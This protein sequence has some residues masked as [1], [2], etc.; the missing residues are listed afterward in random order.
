M[1]DHYAY[2]G[3]R[4]PRSE[5]KHSTT[6]TDFGVIF[7]DWG[8]HSGTGQVLYSRSYH[9]TSSKAREFLVKIATRTSVLL[10]ASTLETSLGG[11]CRLTLL[12]IVSDPGAWHPW[13]MLNICRTKL[14]AHTALDLH[15]TALLIFFRRPRTGIPPAELTCHAVAC[16]RG[17]GRHLLLFPQSGSRGPGI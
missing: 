5:E 15:S 1:K 7:R 12:W 4:R 11:V 13:D 9:K 2:P 10:R 6:T 16:G 8:K 17:P 3:I 14:S